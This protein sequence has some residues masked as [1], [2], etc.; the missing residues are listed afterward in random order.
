MTIPLPDKKATHLKKFHFVKFKWDRRGRFFRD[1]WCISRPRC[2][3]GSDRADP[4]M[5]EDTET[6]LQRSQ[7]T[8]EPIFDPASSKE[9]FISGK[10]ATVMLKSFSVTSS[11]D[12]L[13]VL[14]ASVDLSAP[15]AVSA[16]RQ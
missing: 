1:F 4:A 5:A 9:P 13:M 15:G 6:T 16:V 14:V 2:V 11:N 12:L 10:K 3:S 7:S 8:P